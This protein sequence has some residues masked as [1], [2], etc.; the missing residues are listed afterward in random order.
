MAFWKVLGS[1]ALFGIAAP[2]AG[3]LG[4]GAVGIA[5]AAAVAAKKK[6]QRE[7]DEVTAKMAKEK[8][9]HEKQLRYFIDCAERFK[10]HK[11]FEEFII[12]AVAVG[13]SVANS[14]GHITKEERVE[15]EEFILGISQSALPE[16]IKNN[17]KDMYKN[18][19]TF[20]EAMEY[21]N[22]IMK[23]SYFKPDIIEDIITLVMDAD[24]KKHPNEVAYKEAW[25]QHY[26]SKAA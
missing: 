15:L 22:I 14:D 7:H 26:Q 10:E 1:V 2:I 25:K 17:L 4:M 6:H 9:K 12:A 8:I 21:V 18:P 16:V 20:N 3:P 11:K 5:A 24:D 19:P 23:E 13:I